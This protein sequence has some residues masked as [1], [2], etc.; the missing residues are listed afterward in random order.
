M[1]KSKLILLFGGRRVNSILDVARYF[2][3]RDD[4]NM[5]HK[6]L[7]KLCYYAY[8]WNL[9]L[10]DEPLFPEE[11]QAWV[12]GPVSPVLYREYREYG[13]KKIPPVNQPEIESSTRELLD[14]VYN[15]YG[16]FDGDEL[17]ALTHSEDPWLEVREGLAPY[18]ASREVLSDETIREYYL[19][20]YERGQND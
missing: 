16:E 12:H 14:V 11:F 9:A 7:Q 6:K 20:A 8:A 13:W 10:R 17:E 5:T 18:E 15:T 2:L 1:K 4:G 19:N 3:S